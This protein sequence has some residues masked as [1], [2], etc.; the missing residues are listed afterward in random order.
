[1]HE[2]AS[3]F[4]LR[5]QHPHLENRLRV[6]PKVLDDLQ[7]SSV[8]GRVSNQHSA[9][10]SGAHSGAGWQAVSLWC[11]CAPVLWT[12]PALCRHTGQQ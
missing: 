11:S 12:L 4:A 10:Q 3:V 1:M 6:V 2:H 9:T 7:R 8:R 5:L